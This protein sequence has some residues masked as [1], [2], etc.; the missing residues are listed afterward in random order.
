M[1]AH[2][3]TVMLSTTVRVLVAFSA[4]SAASSTTMAAWPSCFCRLHFMLP[5]LTSSD[6][7]ST[8]RAGCCAVPPVPATAVPRRLSVQKD[9]LMPS[10]HK[11]SSYNTEPCQNKA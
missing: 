1:Q 8:D 7:Q 3:L 11:A 2:A 9:K 5:A 6:V 10:Q 4:P